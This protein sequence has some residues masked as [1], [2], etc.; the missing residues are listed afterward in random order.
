L[1][2]WTLA[3][4]AEVRFDDITFNAQFPLPLD[5]GGELV[6]TFTYAEKVAPPED[7]GE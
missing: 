4:H 2:L 3:G 6:C 5:T 7:A 1:Q